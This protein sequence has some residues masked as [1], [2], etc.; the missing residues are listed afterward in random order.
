MRAIRVSGSATEDEILAAIA[1]AFG[2]EI[3]DLRKM[4]AEG[5]VT[6]E[7]I[8]QIRPETAAK[9]KVFPVRISDETLSVAAVDPLNASML[10]GLRKQCP[11]Q[12]ELVL[13][14]EQD[15]A[16]MLRTYYCV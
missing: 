14:R 5:A 16:Y 13:A 8:E 2:L 10:E 4:E 15:I 3:V 11:K 9:Y 12:I 6:P 7:L 1:R